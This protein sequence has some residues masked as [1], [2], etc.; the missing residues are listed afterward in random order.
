MTVQ[1]IK[2]NVRLVYKRSSKLT[3]VAVCVAIAL[4]TVTLLVLRSA[5]LDAQAQAD[6]LKQQAQQ[7]EQ[8]NSSLED[9]I[10]SLG[11][12]DSVEQIAKDELG[13]VNP[14]TVIIEPEN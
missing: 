10:G 4:S 2:K 5:T 12:L 3:K 11:S 9:K 13:L 7:L 14:D 1:E 6:A 8:E